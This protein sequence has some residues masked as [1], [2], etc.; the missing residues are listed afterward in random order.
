MSLPEYIFIV[1]SFRTGTTLLRKILNTSTDI[2]I[3]GETHF[4]GHLTKPGFRRDL[5]KV[6]DLTADAGARRIVTHI[7]DS[8]HSNFWRWIQHNVDR[9][10]FLRKVLESDRTDRA[11]FDLVMAFYAKD[12]P[13]RGEKTPAH[14]HYVPTLVEWFPN[15]K[16][17]HTLRDPR[18]IFASKKHKKNK[19]RNISL[20]YRLARQS[21]LALELYLSLNVVATWLRLARL[22]HR[23]QRLYPDNYYLSQ[24]EDL[25]ANPTDALTKLCN[26]LGVEFREE[27]LQPTV[28]NSSFVSRQAQVQGFDSLAIDRWRNHLHPTLNKWFVFWCK[29]YLVEFGYQL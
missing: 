28:V 11:L 2:A 15:A 1:G 6:G 24:Y 5:A 3:C 16:I 26:F 21:E 14:I 10:E 19:Q 29:K 23:Y 12:K 25:I 8:P 9:E 27:M 13:V 20:R 17:I 22:H 7:Y 18:A 4:L